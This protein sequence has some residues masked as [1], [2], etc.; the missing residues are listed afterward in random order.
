[1]SAT[2]LLVEDNHH[3]MK[4]NSEILSAKGYRVLEADTLTKGRELFIQETPSLI[5]L[6]IM[7]PDGNGI[8]LCEELRKGSDVPILFLSAKKEDEDIIAGLGAGG[9][10]YLPKPYS[11][12][13]LLKRVEAMLNRAS[14][15][16]DIIHR[17]ALD[18]DIFASSVSL[19]G[20]ELDIKKGK[21]FDVFF[22]L[23][24]NEDKMFSVEQI[25]ERIWKQPMS[26]DD[27]AIR[28]IVTSLRKSLAHSGYTITSEYGKGYLFE[29]G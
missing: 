26:A 7:L 2:I 23:A 12:N 15:I 22:F 5:I 29:R 25:Y 1:M 18:I 10:D 13:I 21:E 14:R 28:K 4:I 27:P 8:E 20:V 24:K 19:N 6:D 9:D 17:G 16:P 3:Y 11:L